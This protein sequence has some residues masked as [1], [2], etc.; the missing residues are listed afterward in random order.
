MFLNDLNMWN[1]VVWKAPVSFFTGLQRI[2]CCLCFISNCALFLT[3]FKD[4]VP[5]EVKKQFKFVYFFYVFCLGFLNAFLSLCH[6]LGSPRGVPA[7]HELQ[8]DAL[9]YHLCSCCVH[10]SNL[11]YNSVPVV[12]TTIGGNE[13]RIFQFLLLAMYLQF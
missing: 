11:L 8:D 4:H 9:F 5:H 13:S 1:A 2:T 12:Q 10:S 3:L 7:L 6:S